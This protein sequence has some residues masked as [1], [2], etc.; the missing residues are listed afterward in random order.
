MTLHLSPRTLV[1]L[2][3]HPQARKLVRSVCDTLTELEQAGCHPRPIAA[4]RRVLTNHQPTPAGRC[5]T[6]R[7]MTWRRRPFPCV[8]WH[9]VHGELLGMFTDP[10]HRQPRR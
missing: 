5:P 6:C 2:A 4:L 1:W 8:V 3:N 10:G 9:Q 7:R